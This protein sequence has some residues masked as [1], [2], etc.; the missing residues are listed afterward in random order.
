MMSW[1]EIEQGT[2]IDEHD[3]HC[4]HLEVGDDSIAVLVC[5]DSMGECDRT[6]LCKDCY[7]DHVAN[8]KESCEVCGM[9]YPISRISN[10]S[11]P[12]ENEKMAICDPCLD[13]PKWVEILRKDRELI[14]FELGEDDNGW[15]EEDMDEHDFDDGGYVEVEDDNT[16]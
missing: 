3:D 15:D 2:R 13:T 7:D 4:E 11:A 9:E 14:K 5:K 1:N 16:Y 6:H 12:F 8:G 10:Y